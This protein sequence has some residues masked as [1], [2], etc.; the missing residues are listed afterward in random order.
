MTTTI[1]VYPQSLGKKYALAEPGTY[2]CVTGADASL[3]TEPAEV[4]DKIA[5]QA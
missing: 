5:T 1:S 2:G 3:P 4:W